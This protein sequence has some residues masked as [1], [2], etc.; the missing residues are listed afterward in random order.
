MVIIERSR[1]VMFGRDQTWPQAASVISSWKRNVEI[2][3][4]GLGA[5]DMRVA[6]HRAARRHAFDVSGTVSGLL[7]GAPFACRR[8]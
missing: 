2:G 5:V 3:L 6:E 1:L 7:M 8:S 4:G